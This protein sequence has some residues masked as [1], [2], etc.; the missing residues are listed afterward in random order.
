MR[1]RPGGRGGRLYMTVGHPDPHCV[2][3]GTT[4]LLQNLARS[5]ARWHARSRRSSWTGWSCRTGGPLRTR[6]TAKTFA[7]SI[8]KLPGPHHDILL[9]GEARQSVDQNFRV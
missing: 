9:A 4:G 5:T 6:R 2:I 3:V 7:N 8:Y 1:D